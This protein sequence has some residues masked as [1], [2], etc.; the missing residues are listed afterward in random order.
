MVAG[1]QHL[2][3]GAD[4]VHEDLEHAERGHVGAHR[5]GVDALRQRERAAQAEVAGRG[6]LRRREVARD[7]LRLP[8]LGHLARLEP[9]LRRCRLAV[10]REDVHAPEVARARR[11]VE[12]GGVRERV[13][14]RFAAVVQ[15]PLERRIRRDADA[16]PSG[17]LRLVGFG[18]PGE[19]E[20]REVAPER[21]VEVVGAEVGDLHGGGGFRGCAEGYHTS[22][23]ASTRAQRAGRLQTRRVCGILRRSRD[24]QSRGTSAPHQP[25]E[26]PR[27]IRKSRDA[28]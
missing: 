16:A 6:P 11:E 2:V 25:S 5:G 28:P 14:R 19:R 17:G 13:E 21:A 4:A 26:K 22:R 8:G 15:D 23:P 18:D 3:R 20:A 7:P 27:W 1:E 9:R 10:V 12:R 24:I